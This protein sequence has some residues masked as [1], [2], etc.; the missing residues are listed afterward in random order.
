MGAFR[1][2]LARLSVY[3]SQFRQGVAAGWGLRGSLERLGV[4]RRGSAPSCCCDA[5]LAGSAPSGSQEILRGEAMSNNDEVDSPVAGVFWS[6]AFAIVACV[7]I[8]W[9]NFG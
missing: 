4:A 5:F 6:L 8:Y 9:H 2:R 7:A 1:L 3:G